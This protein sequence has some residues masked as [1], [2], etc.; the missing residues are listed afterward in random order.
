MRKLA[1]SSQSNPR[2]INP[3]QFCQLQESTALY[4]IDFVGQ[5]LSS[6]Q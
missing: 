1:F 6:V 3:F 2:K 4:K 5:L